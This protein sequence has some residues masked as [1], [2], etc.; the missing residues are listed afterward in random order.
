M[1][2]TAHLAEGNFAAALAA[3]DAGLALKPGDGFFTRMRELVDGYQVYQDGMLEKRNSIY[4]DYPP[5]VHLE[6]Y[7]KCNASC[8]FCPYETLDRLGTRM[9]DALISKVINDLTDI[10]ASVPFII[11]PQ[12]VNE[13]FLDKRIFAVF[14]EIAA[15]LP[16]ANRVINTNA[17][18][19]SDG[20]IAKLAKVTNVARMWISLNEHRPGYYEALMKLPLAHTIQRLDAI[21][22]AKLDGRLSFPIQVG[23]VG[24]GTSADGEFQDWVR[25]RYSHFQPDLLSRGDW[26]GQTPLETETPMAIGCQRWFDLSITA[27]GQVA[28]CCMDGHAAHPIGDITDTHALDIYNGP[29]YRALRERGDSRLDLGAPCDTCSFY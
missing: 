12:K 21:H 24:D 16:N 1:L 17:A 15:K 7:A 2:A 13:P 23:R 26:A 8:G 14:A 4:M 18:A 3:I 27:T 19:L 29:G 25:N 9:P 6:T 10:P 11:A 22:V 5:V 20:N 28:L